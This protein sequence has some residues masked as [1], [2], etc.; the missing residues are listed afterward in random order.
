MTIRFVSR[1]QPQLLL[2][3][4][5][6]LGTRGETALHWAARSGHGAM[7]EQLISAGPRWMRPTKTAVAPEGFSESF[8]EWL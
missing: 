2:L 1:R 4:P 3:P 6:I 5:R 8:R 7:V